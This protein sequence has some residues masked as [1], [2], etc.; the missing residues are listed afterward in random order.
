MFS[1]VDNHAPFEELLLSCYWAL[2]EIE[3]LTL[4]H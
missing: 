3:T 2:V 4:G 1:S